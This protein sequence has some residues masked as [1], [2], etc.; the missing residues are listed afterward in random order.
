MIEI[1]ITAGVAFAVFMIALY[2]GALI[3]GS[4]ETE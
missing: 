2:A 1:L 4:R 3:T